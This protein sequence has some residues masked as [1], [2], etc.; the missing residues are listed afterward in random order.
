MKLSSS[1]LPKN[2]MALSASLSSVCLFT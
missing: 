2:L 1:I